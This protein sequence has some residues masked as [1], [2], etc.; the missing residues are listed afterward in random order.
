[1]RSVLSKH[2]NHPVYQMHSEVVPRPYGHYPDS[3]SISVCS[4]LH[5]Q[6]VYTADIILVPAAR[7]IF[8]YTVSHQLITDMA[9]C[10]LSCLCKAASG[11]NL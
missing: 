2:R 9:A 1:M 8:T 7:E 6:G 3:L 5:W 10:K 11:L 4:P